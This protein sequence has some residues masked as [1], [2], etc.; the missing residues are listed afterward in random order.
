M[1]YMKNIWIAVAVLALVCANVYAAPTVSSNRTTAT[2]QQGNKASVVSKKKAKEAKEA[3]KAAAKAAKKEAAARAAK[4]EVAQSN[5]SSAK[6]QKAEKKY[7]TSSKIQ[8][9]E[10]KYGADEVGDTETVMSRFEEM[11]SMI[12]SNDAIEDMKTTEEQTVQDVEES[13][14][15]SPS[16]PTRK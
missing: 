1:Q 7:D 11:E 5:R 9:A 16:A 8:K 6:I 10:K 12:L 2:A 4:Q 3:A 14:V 15:L 13:E